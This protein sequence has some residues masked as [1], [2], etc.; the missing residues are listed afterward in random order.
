MDVTL[1]LVTLLSLALAAV[2]TT[3]AWRL[4]REERRRSDARVAALSAAIDEESL[5]L[6]QV[7]VVTSSDL[8]SAAEPRESSSRVPTAVFAVAVAI[9]AIGTFLYFASSGRTANATPTQSVRH[10]AGAAARTLPIELTALTHERDA[11]RL[12]VRGIVRNP[13]SGAE[14]D[15]LNAVVSVFDRD[16]G[17]VANS[18]APIDAAALTPGA[19][20]PFSVTI[21][22]VND[23]GRYRVG[24]RS[25]EQVVPHVDRRDRPVA[26]A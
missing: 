6:H 18:A 25:D 10:G 16:G 19:T 20:S 11:D 13:P 5:P 15:R 23:V 22:N 2:M 8:F 17:L 14:L 26:Q 12:T 3:Y 1:V 7:P 9:A 21:P 4:A 24:F